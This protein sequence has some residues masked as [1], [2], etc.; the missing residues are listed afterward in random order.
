MNPSALTIA[1][2]CASLVALGA[3]APQAAAAEPYEIQAVLGLTGQGAFLGKQVNDALL[4]FEKAANATGGIHGRQVHIAIRDDQS[5]PQTAVQL[6]SDIVAAHPPLLLG[7]VLVASCN[8]MAPLVANGPVM[9]CFSPG[10]HPQAGSYVYTSGG[11]TFDQARALVQFFR[12]K[13]WTK[14]ALTTSTDATGQ[15][16]DEGFAKLLAEDQNKDVKLAAH[17]HFNVTDVSVAAQIEEIRAAKPQAVI[18]WSTGSPAGTVF[19]GLVQAGVDLPVGTTGG[20][21]TYAQMTQFAAFLPKELYLPTSEWPVN[22][23]PRIALDPGVTAKQKEFY[24]A[25]TAA[26]AKPDEGSALAW[27]PASILTDALR[28][29]PE[30]V[31]AAE[32]RGHLLGLQKEAGVSGIYDFT[33]T[34]QRGLSIDNVVVT[35]WDGG[36]RSWTVMSKPTGIPLEP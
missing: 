27:D 17:V 7:S 25:F 26:G 31:T 11:S 13:G 6:T 21:M 8:A 23:D 30:N 36:A 18:V 10:I 19:R 4:L 3:L 29:L 33:K 20:N 16:A 24:A 5:N 34:P 2:G 12:L 15:D 1:V 32:L 14:L 28:E 35:R 9:Y 22:G